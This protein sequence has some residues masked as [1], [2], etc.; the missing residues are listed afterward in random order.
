[1]ENKE[2]L[3]LAAEKEYPTIHEQYQYDAFIKGA[4]WHAERGYSEEDMLE[5]MQFI[6]SQES[7]SNTSSVSKDTAL[8]Y[9]TQF[10]KNESKIKI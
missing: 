1:M 9:L 4:K 10:K 8:Y 3:E 5:F 6:I 2:T 7:L